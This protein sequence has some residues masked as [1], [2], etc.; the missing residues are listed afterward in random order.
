M[1]DKKNWEEKLLD[2]LDKKSFHQS[3][4]TGSSEIDF[5]AV[6]GFLVIGYFSYSLISTGWFAILGIMM[7]PLLVII[8]M[9]FVKRKVETGI[10]IVGQP[11]QTKEGNIRKEI[12]NIAPPDEK[13]MKNKKDYLVT[14]VIMA[15][16]WPIVFI[17]F[18]RYYFELF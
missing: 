14:A 9:H 16:I 1:E 11:N 10:E 15:I 2:E 13:V 18:A 8:G 6:I 7:F 12:I 4:E 3:K 17:F 5:G